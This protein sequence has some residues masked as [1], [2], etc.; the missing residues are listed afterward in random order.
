MATLD[1]LPPDQRAVLQLVLQRGRSYDEI[2]RLLSI[3]RGAVRQRAVDALDALGPAGVSSGAPE[4]ALITDY[5]LGQ[6]PKDVADQVRET[7]AGSATDNAWASDLSRQL[8]PLGG[9]LGELPRLRA[10]EADAAVRGPQATNSAHNDLGA[11]VADSREDYW[12]EDDDERDEPQSERAPRERPTGSRRGGALLLAGVAAAAVVVLVL[13][14]TGAFSGGSGNPT[15]VPAKASSNPD[16]KT[17]TS[18]T[19]TFKNQINLTAPDGAKSP[20]G[21]VQVEQIGSATGIV[22]YASGLQ[23]NTKHDAY[24]VWLSNPNGSSKFVGWE[25]TLV[26]KS[27]TLKAVG[28]LPDDANKYKQL[29]VTLETQTNPT[30]PGQVVLSGAFSETPAK[31]S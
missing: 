20:A 31:H 11:P 15:S 17:T 16:P 22:I 30:K 24:A 18:A 9:K 3:D 14:I 4:R 27:G 1:S 6:L 23:P 21:I 28:P 29:L 5:L 26:G 12:L 8:A 2:A 7:L 13:V 19:G 25:H 10:T